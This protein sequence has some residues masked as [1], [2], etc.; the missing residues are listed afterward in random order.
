MHISYGQ[1]HTSAHRFHYSL[2]GYLTP[3]NSTELAWRHMKRSHTACEKQEWCNSSSWEQGISSQPQ[4]W[5]NWDFDIEL[6]GKY[7]NADR[8][9]FAS[10]NFAFHLHNCLSDRN[11]TWYWVI[12]FLN[13]SQEGFSFQLNRNCLL[14]FQGQCQLTTFCILSMLLLYTFFGS[15]GSLPNVALL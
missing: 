1:T 12:F 7:C 13:S 10:V 5:F 2:R 4:Y 9:D 6:N 15:L 14:G 3:L 8:N 11:I